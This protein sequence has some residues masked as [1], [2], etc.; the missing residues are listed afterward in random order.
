M[1]PVLDKT[2]LAR[3]AQAR[4]AL[5]KLARVESADFIEQRRREGEIVLPF[6]RDA[7][8]GNRAMLVLAEELGKP[9]SRLYRAAKFAE[10]FPPTQLAHAKALAEDAGFELTYSAL[11]LL[12]TSKRVGSPEQRLQLL[13][14]MIREG[15]DVRRLDEELRSLSRTASP[16]SGTGCAGDIRALV[17][18]C[19]NIRL[20]ACAW[21]LA[22]ARARSSHDAAIQE[23]ASVAFDLIVQA[24]EDLYLISVGKTQGDDEAGTRARDLPTTGTLRIELEPPEP[25]LTDHEKLQLAIAEELAPPLLREMLSR[26]L[27]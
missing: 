16:A 21:G 7:V 4:N 24:Y 11:A 19:Q 2:M 14:Q 13:E 20:N 6:L 3:I 9:K 18:A 23:K 22:M 25:R 10:V 12:S 8:Y 1:K 17:S 15:W 26:G 5:E 27:R